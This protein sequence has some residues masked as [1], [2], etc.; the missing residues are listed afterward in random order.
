[1]WVAGGNTLAY[2]TD[3]SGY[4]WTLA[5]NNPLETVNG[6]A[7]SS[8]ANKW[9]AVGTS[10]DCIEC[11]ATSSNGAS[12][13]STASNPFNLIRD[14]TVVAT[15]YC[16]LWYNDGT[17]AA[18]MVGG[19]GADGNAIHYSTNNGGSWTAVASS[20]TDPLNGGTCYALS[21]NNSTL[22]VSGTDSTG[23]GAIAYGSDYTDLTL[24]SDQLF[25][26]PVRGI[27]YYS[28]KWAVTGEQDST[29]KNTVATTTDFTS[30]STSNPLESVTGYG[31]GYAI[32]WISTTTPPP[33]P[34]CFLGDAPV[35][36]PSGYKRIDS[37]SLGDKV[38]TPDGHKTITKIIKQSYT[39]GKTTNPYRI[40]KGLYNAT[41]DL[42]ISPAHKVMVDGTLIEARSLG[43]EQIEQTEITYYN[44]GITGYSS[45]I[46]AGV[47]VESLG[48][49]VTMTLPPKYLKALMAK[50]GKK[51]DSGP[52]TITLGTQN[53]KR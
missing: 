19:L 12:W 8:S 41:E 44:L 23:A 27:G 17:T 50:L 2:S 3:V 20:S 25:T 1:M 10:V 11:V 42:L 5:N 31:G 28:T 6:V 45:M 24:V 22:V 49:T 34:P 30:W 15:G 46:V 18:W 40:P 16:V 47:E 36:T 32:A 7:W 26:G 43:L 21:Y 37:L 4:S 53:R 14:P 33:P 48:E 52:L 9:M 35:L 29:S 13:S 39:P 51:L 38:A